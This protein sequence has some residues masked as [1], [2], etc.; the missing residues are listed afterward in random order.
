[1]VWQAETMS[2]TEP[3]HRLSASLSDEDEYRRIVDPTA[4]TCRLRVMLQMA[5]S[6]R[7]MP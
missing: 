7:F 6:L 5:L 1:M 4:R 2:T 3:R